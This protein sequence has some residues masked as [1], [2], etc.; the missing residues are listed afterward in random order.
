MTEKESRTYNLFL[1]S[2]T[3]NGRTRDVY[4]GSEFFSIPDPGSASNNFRILTQ[5]I[6]F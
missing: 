3:D 6:V 1:D 4:P 2:V 5:K